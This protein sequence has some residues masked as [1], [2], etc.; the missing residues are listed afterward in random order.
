MSYRIIVNG[1]AVETDDVE[2]VL[3]LVDA[4]SVRVATLVREPP[5]QDVHHCPRRI[6]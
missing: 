2:K 4:I 5:A 6:G 1:V 3:K